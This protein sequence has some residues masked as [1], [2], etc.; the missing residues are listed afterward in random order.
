MTAR[1]E[2]REK[3]KRDAPAEAV[4]EARNDGRHAAERRGFRQSATVRAGAA[5]LCYIKI[6]KRALYLPISVPFR[7]A[8]PRVFIGF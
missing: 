6:S 1:K 8:T 4:A 7:I 3:S 2:C 5:R